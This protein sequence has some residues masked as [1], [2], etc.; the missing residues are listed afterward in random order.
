M[1]LESDLHQSK[2]KNDHEWLYLIHEDWGI[3]RK[4]SKSS[5]KQNNGLF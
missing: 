4:L 2:K 5:K 3:V 1:G